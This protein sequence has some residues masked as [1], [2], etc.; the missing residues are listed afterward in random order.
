MSPP[1]V[2]SAFMSLQP[3]E[4]VFVFPS[5]ADAA[6][7]QSR[8][9]QGRILPTSRQNWVYLPLPEGLQRVRTARR[10]DV[11]FD[12]DSEKHAGEF[13]KTVKSLGAI[14][15]S[16]KGDHGWEKVVYLGKEKVEGAVEQVA[17]LP[18]TLGLTRQPSTSASAGRGP[19]SL[20]AYRA[21]VALS[22]AAGPGAY[23]AG[24]APPTAAGSGAYPAGF[25]PRRAP[26]PGE[27]PAGFGPRDVRAPGP[28][29]YPPGFG[30]SVAPR[31]QRRIPSRASERATPRPSL[32]AGL[33]SASTTNVGNTTRLPPPPPGFSSAS[34]T[35][36]Q[37]SGNS[38]RPPPL[39][40]LEQYNQEVLAEI[41]AN[42][43]PVTTLVP[44]LEKTTYKDEDDTK[45]AEKTL[46]YIRVQ[47]AVLRYLEFHASDT[48]S[49]ITARRWTQDINPET[50][51]PKAEQAL[52]LCYYM[53]EQSFDTYAKI[54]DGFVSLYLV[55]Q[56][57][58]P[59]SGVHTAANDILY[60][61]QDFVTNHVEYAY[62]DG[63]GAS[64]GGGGGVM[65]ATP[66]PF[67]RNA[68]P[69]PALALTDDISEV[70]LG[71]GGL[72]AATMA[73][74]RSGDLDQL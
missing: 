20:G 41:M 6:L 16:P 57:A 33:T 15:A 74:L 58:V 26:G 2:V 12:F 34:T 38:I 13:N 27:F 17:R 50:K 19:P 11:A 28:G 56:S 63:V 65:R 39:S 10:G 61:K 73:S 44:V 53:R 62:P 18:R 54:A 1:T 42:R 32:L 8:C 52:S 30:P 72:G 21:G 5:D 67:R 47:R 71:I 24:F 23:P 64:G 36:G 4:P 43:M 3:L 14:Y 40:L 51:I 69:G 35:T 22:L 29:E 55:N 66:Y 60:W 70:S 9:K 49:P 25:G 7:F 59:G 31:P 45:A 48:L 37:G 68:L 46:P